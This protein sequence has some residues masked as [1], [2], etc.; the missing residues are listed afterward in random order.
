MARDLDFGDPSTWKTEDD[1]EYVRQRIDRVPVEHRAR[2][3]IQQPPQL[4]Q[5]GDSLEMQRLHNFLAK[6]YPEDLAV[7]GQ[8]PVGLAIQLLTDEAGVNPDSLD[9]DDA[10]PD[11]TKWKAD[12]LQAEI[13]K[14]RQAGRDI[15][16]V[17]TKT[18]AATALTADDATNGKFNA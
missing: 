12:E 7:E 6:Y 4:M 14:R 5:T 9:E 3:A 16:K 8:T 13:G 1:I 18:D 11:Y 2:L 15:P 17:T 10:A